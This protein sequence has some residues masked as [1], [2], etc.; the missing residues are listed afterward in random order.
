MRLKLIILALLVPVGS[1]GLT[2]TPTLTRTQTPTRTHTNTQTPTVTPTAT[3]TPCEGGGSQTYTFAGGQPVCTTE[4]S[5]EPG[6]GAS[7]RNWLIPANAEISDDI[8]STMTIPGPGPLYSSQRLTCRNYPGF[9]GITGAQF[10]SVNRVTLSNER[11]QITSGGDNMTDFYVRM[12]NGV[13][14]DVNDSF[15]PNL[16]YR[17]T[18][19][20]TT[21]TTVD[22]RWA[23]PDGVTPVILSSTNFGAGLQTTRL[24]SGNTTT[25]A[26]VDS[27]LMS[28]LV[29]GWT[30]TPTPTATL[31]ATLTPTVTETPTPTPTE[32]FTPS[33]TPV[34]AT[35]TPTSTGTI[36]PTETTT[37]TATITPSPTPTTSRTRTPTLTPATTF[38]PT[39]TFMVTWVPEIIP[40]V[41]VSS[42][43][44]GTIVDDMPPGNLAC[45][46]WASLAPAAGQVV[47]VK[48]RHGTVILVSFLSPWAR[49]MR[50]NG[51]C[52]ETPVTVAG[53]GTVT[54]GWY[55][56]GPHF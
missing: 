41:Q 16:A 1:F 8:Y 23:E 9:T 4:S 48:D 36:T 20:P 14:H 25:T 6:T 15:G 38:T 26:E 37:Q 12:I 34:G 30:Y 40:N 32:T 33:L 46:I 51:P 44:G 10:I 27:L 43:T 53:T 39:P 17:N 2:N 5:A 54:L 18:P 55:R 52:I 22:Y 42:S 3:V 24:I 13:A 7:Q 35:Y 31:T 29:C 28:A 11:Y 49:Y 21:E 50:N 56:R 47:E 45:I 19:W